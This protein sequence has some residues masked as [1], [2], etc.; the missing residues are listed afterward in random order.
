MGREIIRHFGH[1]GLEPVADD[2]TALPPC[3]RKGVEGRSVGDLGR[4][5]EPD[6]AIYFRYF[7]RIRV[8]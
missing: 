6:A 7:F 5:A 1:R 4:F 8:K 2:G 3:Y